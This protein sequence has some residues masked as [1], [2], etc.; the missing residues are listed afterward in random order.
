MEE[1]QHKCREREG[2]LKV[3]TSLSPT[4]P[5]PPNNPFKERKYVFF[6][7]FFW[8]W[9][10]AHEAH[11]MEQLLVLSLLKEEVSCS[12]LLGK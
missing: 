4:S 6:C 8:N 10:G 1:E 11:M 7:F 2:S 5:P 3:M 12:A 9:S